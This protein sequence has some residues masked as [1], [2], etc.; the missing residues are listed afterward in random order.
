MLRLSR[1]LSEYLVSK[2]LGS[3]RPPRRFSR[4]RPP[5]QISR[6]VRQSQSPARFASPFQMS[7]PAGRASSRRNFH[8]SEH[9]IYG[10]RLRRRQLRSLLAPPLHR[11]CFS[12]PPPSHRRPSPHTP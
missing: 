2:I 3:Q 11:Y 7:C 5:L 6:L 8:F 12:P 1:R 10:T 9:G 4:S